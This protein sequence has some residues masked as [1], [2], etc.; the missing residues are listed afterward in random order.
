[1]GPPQAQTHLPMPGAGLSCWDSVLWGRGWFPLPPC[2]PRRPP[3]RRSDP[4]R[5]SWFKDPTCGSA[6]QLPRVPAAPRYVWPGLQGPGGASPADA[7]V[8]ARRLCPPQR[9]REP[10][11]LHAE[12]WTALSVW[13]PHKPVSSEGP[14]VEAGRRRE[15]SGGRLLCRSLAPGV[16]TGQRAK[17]AT[18]DDG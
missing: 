4:R 13:A 12:V 15:G 17:G 14:K 7:E 18:E 3:L 10:G 9:P 5:R 6:R 16:L 1:M 8:T 2:G 11:R